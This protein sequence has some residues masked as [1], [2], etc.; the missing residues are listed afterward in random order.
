MSNNSE[1]NGRVVDDAGGKSID[2]IREEVQNLVR[3][4]VPDE[5]DHVDA[6]MVQFEGRESELVETLRTM[7]E[8]QVAQG[9]RTQSKKKKEK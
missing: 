4:V 5:I 6:M 3:R 8:R 7:L 9:A 1:S 2:E